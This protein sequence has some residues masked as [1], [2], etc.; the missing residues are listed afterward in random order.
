MKFIHPVSNCSVIIGLTVDNSRLNRSA[1]NW[2]QAGGVRSCKVVGET[3]F[4]K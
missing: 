3:D 2:E 1:W 4:K